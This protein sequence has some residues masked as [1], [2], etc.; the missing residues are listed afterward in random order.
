MSS[1]A[2]AD[3]SRISGAFNVEPSR[4]VIVKDPK[5][6]L[7]DPSADL[8]I[9]EG[10]VESIMRFN[11]QLPVL[12]RKN[13]DAL[14][15]VDGRQRTANAVEANKRL[16]AAGRPTVKIPVIVQRNDDKDSAGIMRM[17]NAIRREIS[18]MQKAEDAHHLIGGHG[19]SEAEVAVVFG[20]TV[21]AVKNWLKLLDLAAPVK[22]AV[23]TG[24]ITASAAVKLVELPRDQQ[25]VE[26]DKLLASANDGKRVSTKSAGKAVD[27]AKGREGREKP[28]GRLLKK[29]WQSTEVDDVTRNL[30]GWVLGMVG[31]AKCDMVEVI[32]IVTAP[33]PKK[34][35][36]VKAR[37]EK[38]KKGEAKA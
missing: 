14:E 7:F 26:L 15:V 29:I 12:V 11:V 18:I 30:I 35:K 20:V 21:P 28:S 1:P 31:P 27:A 33:K 25:V 24:A 6:A 32:K 34:E 22:K 3:A 17:L 13:G 8:P 10:M 37:K 16:E 4:L 2:I 23:D 5:N 9:N 38:A 19:Y 36:K